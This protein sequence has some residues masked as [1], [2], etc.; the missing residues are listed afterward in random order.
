LINTKNKALQKPFYHLLGKQYI[1]P[2]LF[3]TSSKGILGKWEV[4]QGKVDQ[5][6]ILIGK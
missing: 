3:D 4:I 1:Y 6:E 5:V 2:N